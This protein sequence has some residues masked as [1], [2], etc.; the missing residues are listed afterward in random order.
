MRLEIVIALD[1]KVTCNSQ[2]Y[3]S[4][5]NKNYGILRRDT[6]TVM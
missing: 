5:D 6:L 4:Y 3:H 2:D 1:V